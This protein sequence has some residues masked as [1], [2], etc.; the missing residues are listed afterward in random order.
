MECS[1]E[2]STIL[3]MLQVQ[4]VFI[5]PAGGQAAIKARV[6]H[7]KFEVE[8]GDLLTLLNVYAAYDKNKTPGWCQ[9]QFLNNKALRR[10]TEIRMQMHSMMKRLHIPLV[11]CKGKLIQSTVLC[12][13]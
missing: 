12:T 5:K 11:S 1:E 2:L 6:A 8:E 13:Q 4:N 10:A 3:A 7:R 9:K